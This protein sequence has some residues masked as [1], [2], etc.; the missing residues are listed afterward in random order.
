M[1]KDLARCIALM[2]D[3][4]GEMHKLDKASADVRTRQA[5]LETLSGQL[6]EAQ[7]A[8]QVEE[9]S[10]HRS[11]ERVR[12]FRPSAEVKSAA[13]ERALS[14]QRAELE[15]LEREAEQ[16]RRRAEAAAE[17]AEDVRGA[18]DHARQRRD[19]VE[20]AAAEAARRIADATDQYHARLFRSLSAALANAGPS[21]ST[22][23][24]LSSSSSSSTDGMMA[25]AVTPA[26]AGSRSRTPSR[27]VLTPATGRI[28]E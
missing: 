4:R 28:A 15:V 18:V 20:A 21:S 17:A 25:M 16:A 24:S 23:V 19:H 8:H 7:A 9:R 5:E 10:A 11:E 3:A 6:A 26:K 14:S 22:V 27:G 1:E 2:G 13:A 12:D